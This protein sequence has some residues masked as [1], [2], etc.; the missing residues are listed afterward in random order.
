[1]FIPL[2]G[3]CNITSYPG[4]GLGATTQVLQ[5]ILLTGL[6]VIGQVMYLDADKQKHREWKD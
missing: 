2:L 6:I 5:I 3:K 1:M 4:F